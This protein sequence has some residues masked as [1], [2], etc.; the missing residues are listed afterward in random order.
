[1]EGVNA[2]L[3]ESDWS[4]AQSSSQAEGCVCTVLCYVVLLCIYVLD[5]SVTLDAFR[6]I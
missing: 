4:R 1:M 3:K 2:A 5:L 6:D